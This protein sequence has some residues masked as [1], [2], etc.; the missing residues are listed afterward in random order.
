MPVESSRA[1]RAEGEATASGPGWRERVR[2]LSADEPDAVERPRV[3]LQ[4]T[5]R[6]LVRPADSPWSAPKGTRAD[7]IRSTGS[8]RLGA[9]PVTLSPAG[10]WVSSGTGWTQYS[11]VSHRLPLDPRHV[12]WLTE[13]ASLHRS[14]RPA[15]T[16]QESA[17]L[18]LDDFG[19]PLLWA[20]LE[21]A[22]ALDI[23][24]VTGARTADV[25]TIRSGRV[26]LDARRAHGRLAL[27]P[28]LE[29]VGGPADEA[30]PR[31]EPLVLGAHDGILTGPIGD[32]GL[33]RATLDPP[34]VELIRLDRAL[35][36]EL[37]GLLSIGEPLA[38]PEAEADEFVRDY[39]PRLASAVPV[40]SADASVPLPAVRPP[41][42]LLTVETKP[43]DV[44]ELT[45]EWEQGVHRM[46]A[47]DEGPSGVL[48]GIDAALFAAERLPGLEARPDVRVVFVGGRPDYRELTATPSLTITTV[49]TDDPDWFDLG[50]LVRVNGREVSFRQI[51]TAIARGRSR[52][53]LIDKTYLNVE[54]PVFDGLRRL[55]EEAGELGEWE[56]RPRISRYQVELWSA[57]EELADETVEATEW[58]A[59]VD[60]LRSSAAPAEVP[61]PA[62]LVA[63]LRPYQREGFAWL[64][65]LWQHRLGGL[66]ADD[67]GL[68]KTLQAI[69]LML[70]A[71]WSYEPRASV[72]ATPAP[73]EPATEDGLPPFLVVAPTSVLPSWAAELARFAP[74]LD[75]QLIENRRTAARPDADVVVTS[76]ALLRLEAR[77]FAAGRWAALVL[78]EAQAVKNP[79]S[80]V[81]EAVAGVGAPLVY[82]LTGTPMENSLGDLWTLL[83]LTSPGLFASHHRF[84]ESFRVPIEAGSPSR[85]AELRRRMRPFVLRRTKEL[86][87]PELPAR[88]EQVL[89]VDLDPRHRAIYDRVLQTERKKVLG[90]IDDLDRQRFIVFRSITLLR[91]LALDP[92]LIDDEDYGD[93]IAAKADAL[94]ERVRELVAE[95]HR[96]L[97]F[98]QFTSYLARIGARLDAEGI[99]Y[100]YLDGSTLRRGE[101]VDRFREGDAP[102]FLI[103]LKAGGVGLTLTEADYVFLLDPWWNPA[104]ER[105]AIDRTHRIGQTR[106]VTIYRLVAR[107]TVE[108]KV[109]ALRDRKAGLTDAVLD[110]DAA[111][112]S[113][114]DADD[115]R[116][117]LS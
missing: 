83:R 19:S 107:D 90:L 99:G 93:V 105:Q 28:A 98:S 87:A 14:T 8:Y 52:L 7:G 5:V 26:R 64:A 63:E 74:G 70:H 62:G 89:A 96:A 117:L 15:S 111:F 1:A 10:Q 94:L 27:S 50:V 31:P 34:R 55:I 29:I 61:V 58:R 41:S 6:E 82:A 16:P 60:A 17:F 25:A 30:P 24:L 104:A 48:R 33:Y 54:Q 79:R 109:M 91:L 3:G 72:A 20:L 51:F 86:V 22:A 47:P 73:R 57:F 77:R 102:L 84:T 38:V 101:V 88:Q 37:A 43:D 40:A 85:L 42:L 116:A 67:M 39:Y 12:R 53:L 45:W 32:H 92:A 103:S 44:I 4:L 71:R 114:L 69:A 35:S 23:A 56:P 95:G 21:S 36:P 112:A 59:A 78:D 75:V 18:Y 11:Y 65:T 106:P 80:R 76:Y 13:F 100:E 68:G 9:R 115:I 108:E 113:A 110:A 66:L 97:V 46:P 81:H 49:P 2:A